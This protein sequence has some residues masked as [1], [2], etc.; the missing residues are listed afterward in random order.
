MCGMQESVLCAWYERISAVCVV[1]KSQ[2]CVCGMKESVLCVCGMK[3]SV[4][5]AW[6]ERVSSVCVL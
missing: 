5:C 3:E 1:W 4:L 6:Y 2:F